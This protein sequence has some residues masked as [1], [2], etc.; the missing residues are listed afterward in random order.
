MKKHKVIKPNPN[1]GNVDYGSLMG[2]P[3]DV[4][5]HPANNMPARGGPDEMSPNY[6]MNPNNVV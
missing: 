5:D 2:T 3:M 6:S 1:S 4:V